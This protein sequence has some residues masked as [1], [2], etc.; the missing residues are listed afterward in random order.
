MKD[1]GLEGKELE[2]AQGKRLWSHRS[3]SGSRECQLA[4]LRVLGSHPGRWECL[5][6]GRDA[7]LTG[8]IG[9]ELEGP[10]DF[11]S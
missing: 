4:N 8:R 11:H 10:E 7:S 3:P 2:A 1:L 6:M 9:A 5:E